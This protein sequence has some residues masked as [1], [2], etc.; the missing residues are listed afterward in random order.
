M[1][2]Q[3]TEWQNIFANTYDKGLPFKIYK[4]LIKLYTHEEIKTIKLKMGKGPE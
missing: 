1:K 3:P 2:R 4:E